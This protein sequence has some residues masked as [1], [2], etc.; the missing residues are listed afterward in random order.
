[1]FNLQSLKLGESMIVAKGDNVQYKNHSTQINLEDIASEKDF[2]FYNL[3]SLISDKDVYRELPQVPSLI[4]D[5]VLMDDPQEE[6]GKESRPHITI[7]YGLKNEND[8]FAIRKLLAETKP[9][10][11]KLGKI[12]SFRNNGEQPYDV[13][14][15]EILSPELE[16][17][18]YKLR[19]TFENNNQ[20]P[21]Y[22]PHMTI[23]YI[24]PDS[25]KNLEGGHAWLGTEFIVNTAH[26]SHCGGFKLPLPLN[27]N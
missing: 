17:I 8:Y 25:C 14:K 3:Q 24:N 26:F 6:Y 20:F 23:S 12:S 27:R 18:H 19:D 4:S 22:K 5:G 10:V 16:E 7:L 1:M 9:F 21:E 11:I 15:I 2:L 13:L